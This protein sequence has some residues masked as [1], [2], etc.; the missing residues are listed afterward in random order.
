MS[1][2]RSGNPVHT[3]DKYF[4]STTE[5]DQNGALRLT[6]ASA[7]GHG[8]LSDTKLIKDLLKSEKIKVV[9]LSCNENIALD[10]DRMVKTEE[11]RYVTDFDGRGVRSAMREIPVFVNPNTD[12]MSVEINGR[13]LSVN[14]F[15]K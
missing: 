12:Q 11:E 10:V 9:V 3:A 1:V 5:R 7:S 2:W 4:I 8:K 15:F 13:V 14:Q 6:I